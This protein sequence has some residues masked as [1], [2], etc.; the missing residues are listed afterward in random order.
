MKTLIIDL[1]HSKSTKNT[2]VFTYPED[3]T[4]TPAISTLYISKAA[5]VNGVPHRI[6]VTVETVGE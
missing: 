6:Q 4:D 3:E 5:F 1:E 2:E